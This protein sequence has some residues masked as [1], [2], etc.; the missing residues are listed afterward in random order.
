M[1]RHSFVLAGLGL[2]LLSSDALA[3]QLTASW[4]DNSG[5]LA[6]TQLERRQDVDTT[7]SVLADVPPGLTS[8]VDAAVV[9][10][11]TYCYRALAFDA[12]GVSAYTDEV[13]AVVAASN[14]TVT[15]T[16][17]KVGTGTGTVVSSPAGIDCGASCSASYTAGTAVT[18][19]A[20][21]ATGDS[22]DGWTSGGC[23]GTA[24]CTLAGN[25]PA[26]V[27]ASFSVVPADVTPPVVALTVPMLSRRSSVTLSAVASDNVGVTKVEFYV[28]GSLQCTATVAPYTC[29]WRVPAASGKSYVV[30]AKA[31]DPTGNV[32]AS[33]PVTVTPR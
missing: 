14:T 23:A 1:L 11:S 15:L 3:A 7:F 24:V 5:G 21:A 4:T 18:L 19:A 10:G 9:P 33:P 29:A 22:F 13:C 12:A 31:Y 30:Q 2:V 8:Y 26:T 20:T 17:A 28:N 25:A 16:V 27:T 32:G 6:T